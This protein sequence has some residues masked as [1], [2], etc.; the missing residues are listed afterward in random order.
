MAGCADADAQVPTLYECAPRECHRRLSQPLRQP[1][2]G[3]ADRPPGRRVSELRN[4]A[5]SFG[6]RLAGRGL[7]SKACGK[8]GP[9]SPVGSLGAPVVCSPLQLPRGLPWKHRPDPLKRSITQRPCN[10]TSAD[11]TSTTV[12]GR[13]LSLVWPPNLRFPRTCSSPCSA[14][15]IFPSPRPGIGSGKSSGRPSNRRPCRRCRQDAASR[16]CSIRKSRSPGVA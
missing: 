9:R 16:W 7:D 14:L 8:S 5:A 1:V 15:P 13:S 3:W 6:V 2:S 4:G 11:K 10:I 12:S